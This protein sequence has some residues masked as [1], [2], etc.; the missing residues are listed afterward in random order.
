MKW[1]EQKRSG[2]IRHTDTMPSEVYLGID[3]GSTTTKIVVTDKDGNIAYGYYHANE[4]DPIEAVKKGLGLWR[5]EC[6][7]QNVQA[8][9][10][11]SCVT[12]YGENLIKAAFKLDSGIIE[13]IAHFTAAR[14]LSPE[15]TFI[16]DI[17]GQDMKAI[18]VDKGVISRMELNEACSSGC[19]SFIET[20]ARSLG[21]SVSQFAEK[22]CQ[23]Q[24]PCDLGT[25]C[26]VFMNSKVKQV[27][28]ENATVGD[29]SAGLAYS[30]V[31]NALYKV[32][33]LHDHH[34][35]EHMW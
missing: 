22:A 6:R 30:V 33:K 8:V 26:T 18:F 29:I 2:N 11:G 5:E 7:K 15:V 17:G 4:G 31:K 16:L 34:R 23:A 12:G 25:R 35:W 21:H 32:L 10:K 13:T 3:S 1:C 27:L 9:V 14:R 19:G 28:R 24:H 20:F